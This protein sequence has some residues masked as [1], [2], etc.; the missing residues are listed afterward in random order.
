M[1]KAYA[2]KGM[3]CTACAANIDHAVRKIDGIIDVNVSF[4]KNEMV[5]ES[6]VDLTEAIIQ[7]V[8]KAGYKAIP[9]E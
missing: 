2:L 3:M 5:V 7:A 8:K 1:K 4:V 9:I 6:N